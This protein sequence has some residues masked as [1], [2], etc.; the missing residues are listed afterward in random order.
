MTQA[1]C[2]VVHIWEIRKCVIRSDSLWEVL[3]RQCMNLE[4]E[5]KLQRRY[6]KLLTPR[7]RNICPEKLEPASRFSPGM[8][9]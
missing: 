7:T 5:L 3:T 6:R 4:S 9:L 1:E 8:K 2:S